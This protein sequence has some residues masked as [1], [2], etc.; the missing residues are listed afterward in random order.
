[1]HTR[2]NGRWIAGLSLSVGLLAG[3][4][5]ADA[6]GGLFCD[7]QGAVT[8][9][10]AQTGEGIVFGVDRE[11]GRVQAIISIDY[12]GTASEFAWVLPL[13]S[14]PLDVDVVPALS[15]SNVLAMTQPQFFVSRRDEGICTNEEVAFPGREEDVLSS[16]AEPES[17][18]RVID[19]Q[20]VGP[21]DSAVIQS[22]DPQDIR[23]W[24]TDN[25]Y[26][27]SD[28]MMDSVTPY[29]ANGDT[30]LALKLRK[31]NDVGDLEPVVI[32]MAGDEVCVP[33]R[34]TAIAALED[35]QISTVVLSNEGRAIPENYNHVTLNLAKIDWLSGG[36]NYRQVVAEAADEGSGNAF[37]TEFAG[38]AQISAAPSTPAP[39]RPGGHRG[40]DHRQPVRD[41]AR[42]A[43][44][45]PA[46]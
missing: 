28:E 26:F 22:S 5:R 12:Q 31:S 46:P 40:D 18:V 13:Q 42:P 8:F 35:M 9:P 20:E 39:V 6:C 27:V 10:I 29:L 45:P 30:L 3:A 4:Q 15:F 21:Y 14:A 43:G 1:M 32:T 38:D 16:V 37:T 36:A 17:S 25:G 41:A 23:T 44:A 11:H 34:L 2:I 33:I 19:Q 7:S 24:L